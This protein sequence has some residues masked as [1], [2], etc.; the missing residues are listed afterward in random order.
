MSYAPASARPA[1]RPGDPFSRHYA[2]RVHTTTASDIR[3][4]FAM[5]ARPG[6]ISL[7][8][9]MPGTTALPI[10]VVADLAPRLLS[11][12]GAAALQYATAHGDP[13]LREKICDVMALEGIRARAD[14]VLVTVG[15]QQALDL[16]ARIFID[17]GDVV[18]AEAPSYVG[19]LGVFG[20]FQAEVVHVPM[21][22][23]G[24]VPD[25]LDAAI[26]GL[27]AAGRRAKL[28][29]TVP[30]FHNPAGVTLPASRRGRVL[31]ICASAGLLI[32]EDNPYGLLGFGGVPERALHADNPDGVLYL[33]TFSKI[34]A[35]GVRV[36]W[37]VAPPAVRD[38]L[39]LAAESAILCHSSLAQLLV[40]EY[41]CAHP[42]QRHVAGLRDVYQ[43]RR[44][45]MLAALDSAGLGG[46]GGCGWTTPAGGFYVWLS[47]PD[48]I[49]APAMLPRA[50]SRGVA[51]VPGTGFYATHA[52]AQGAA[53][54]R[55]SYCFPEPDLIREGV[56][57]LAA[58][59]EAEQRRDPAGSRAAAVT[60]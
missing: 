11:S 10:D 27:A 22:G 50:V 21:D 56:R 19:A 15:S 43:R 54:L 8:G 9:G 42:W 5:A 2:S 24:L 35:P 45:A 36:G 57:R 14:D 1:G 25:A 16:V 47:L 23:D 33:G 51:Y 29:Y 30:N 59:I 44:D 39:V 12:Q 17:P 18:L 58:V 7:A 46:P 6:V 49:S 20:A 40:R 60:S 28:L 31:D 52:S 3:A 32:V 38:T 53:R 13:L 37:A 55:L 48:G 34:F 26:R 4:L 41:L